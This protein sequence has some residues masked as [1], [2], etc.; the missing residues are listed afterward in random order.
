MHFVDCGAAPESLRPLVK[1]DTAGNPV[2]KPKG[3]E[4]SDFIQDLQS[5][6]KSLCAYC[7]RKCEQ[8]EEE[9]EKDHD[10]EVDR[11]PRDQDDDVD[12]Y[13][14]R[15]QDNTVDH[16]RPRSRF[17]DRTFEW[18]NLVYA[19][20]RCNTK[21]KKD[22]FPAGEDLRAYQG[23]PDLTWPQLEIKRLVGKFGKSFL[24][25]SEKDGY[26]NPRD[27][28]EPAEKFFAFNAEGEILPA[29]DL[30]NDPDDP[31]WSK[32]VRTIADFELNQW[33]IVGDASLRGLRA[34]MWLEMKGLMRQNPA[35]AQRIGELGNTEFPTLVKWA[36]NHPD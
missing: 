27:A 17:P 12:Q 20:Y 13:R 24:P 19:C 33:D 14:G 34:T 6:F 10:N 29:A 16:F 7:E 36:L 4:Y 11:E 8:P 35:F 15:D 28:A 21:V 25:I 23:R 32:A 1:Y 31:K 5:R 18:E 3:K 22:R 26:V 9:P 30:P 2:W